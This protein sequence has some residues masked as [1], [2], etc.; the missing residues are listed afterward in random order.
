LKLEPNVLGPE[1]LGAAPNQCHN[2]TVRQ[3][4]VLFVFLFFSLGRNSEADVGKRVRKAARQYDDH[5][6]ED[7]SAGSDGECFS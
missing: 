3:R 2:S 1:R 7:A 4:T 5:D 6:Y